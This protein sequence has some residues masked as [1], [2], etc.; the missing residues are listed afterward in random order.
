VTP[1]RFIYRKLGCYFKY[2]IERV[3]ICVMLSTEMKGLIV[4]SCPWENIL[5]ASLPQIA[6]CNQ[7]TGE[8]S[9][10]S[11][12]RL[13]RRMLDME[14]HWLGTPM[15]RVDFGQLFLLKGDARSPDVLSRALIVCRDG[16]YKAGVLW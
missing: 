8:G 10:C 9:S 7:L 12:V 16:V 14:T 15:D 2:R 6:P 3:N 5:S 11:G 1:V 4:V 13:G